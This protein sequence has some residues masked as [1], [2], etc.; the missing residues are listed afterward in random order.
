MTDQPS[1]GYWELPAIVFLFDTWKDR[2]IFEQLMERSL[3]EIALIDDSEATLRDRAT[4][5]WADA[6]RDFKKDQKLL[7]IFCWSPQHN[8]NL[9][10]FFEPF[11][12][13]E[14]DRLQ[15]AVKMIVNAIVMFK[16]RG[17]KLKFMRDEN[18]LLLF[19]L[20]AAL[21]LELSQIDIDA[22]IAKDTGYDA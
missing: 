19:A 10:L 20:Q 12:D 17:F 2:E 14:V 6:Y 22:M 9:P 13:E 16:C 21:E 18:R 4:E 7:A 8:T 5:H 15:S 11:L 3:E 1:H